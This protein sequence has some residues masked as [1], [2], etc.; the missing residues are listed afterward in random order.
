MQA[1]KER[2]LPPQHPA[3][4]N[5][6]SA[7]SKQVAFSL[8]LSILCFSFFFLMCIKTSEGVTVPAGQGQISL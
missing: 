2:K 6:S 7:P 5:I 4:T 3:A 8:C 1:V